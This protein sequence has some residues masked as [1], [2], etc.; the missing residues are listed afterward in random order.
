MAFECPGAQRFRQPQPEY[1]KCPSCGEEAEIWTDETEAVC[2]KC[3][4]KVTRQQEQSCLEWCA[5]AKECVGEKSYN[6]YMK[7]R[8]MTIKDKLIEELEMYFGSDA[9]R[10]GHAK[11]VM[12]FA[13]ELLKKEKADWHIVIP[14]SILHDVG[15]KAA[16]NKYGSSAGHLQEKE[17]PEI[18]RAILLKI[19]VRKENIDEICQIIGHHH[20]PG[21]INTQ[22]F[23]VLYDADWLVNLK[24]ETDIH[25]KE[26][27]KEIIGRVFLT[28]TGRR[29]AKEIYIDGAKEYR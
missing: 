14:A 22:N 7:N 1:I 27:L 13:E 8:T 11:K 29:L 9:K 21:R 5:Y 23:K 24:D 4:K 18:A 16:E 25:D 15:I 2:P 12:G 3:G 19:G 17:G 10:I 6:N 20:S 26:R 28:N